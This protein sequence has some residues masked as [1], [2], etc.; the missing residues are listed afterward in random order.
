MQ[1]NG[2]YV[3]GMAVVVVLN[4]AWLLAIGCAALRALDPLGLCFND[5]WGYREAGS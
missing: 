3:V 1:R 2:K 5:A 4:A